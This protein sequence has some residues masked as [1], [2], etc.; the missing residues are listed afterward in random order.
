[1]K[2][3]NLIRVVIVALM[4]TLAQAVLAA[5]VKL[6]WDAKL[7]TDVRTGVRV[8]E[9]FTNATTGAFTYANIGFALDPVN[10]FT[11]TNVTSGTHT[12]VVRAYNAQSESKDSAAVI[13]IILVNVNEV[14]G[15]T[16]TI[17]PSSPSILKVP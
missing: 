1:M 13:A 8:Y 3:K 15:L 5:D 2:I 4:M 14:T 17:I 6:Q 10:I 16:I 11:V 7:A 9:R 12:Y